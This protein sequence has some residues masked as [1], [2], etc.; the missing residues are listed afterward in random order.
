MI[1][2]SRRLQDYAVELLCVKGQNLEF[3]KAII[4][5]KFEHLDIMR[6]QFFWVIKNP[7]ELLILRIRIKS[8]SIYSNSIRLYWRQNGLASFWKPK[9]EIKQRHQTG[10]F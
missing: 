7:E 2:K 3:I 6:A 9:L 8:S 5:G 1:V 4:Q 10:Q